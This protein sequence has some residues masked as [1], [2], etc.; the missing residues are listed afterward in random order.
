MYTQH[1]APLVWAR[2]PVVRFTP[3]VRLT[4]LSPTYFKYTSIY[5]MRHHEAKV[6]NNTFMAQYVIFRKGRNYIY[7]SLGVPELPNVEL[8]PF[9]MG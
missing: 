9:M 7:M 4:P 5:L 8:S 6:L 1:I 2:K 3:L